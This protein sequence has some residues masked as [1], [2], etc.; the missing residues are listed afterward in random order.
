MTAPENQIKASSFSRPL[1]S[2][3]IEGTILPD[4]HVVL[5]GKEVDWAFTLTPLGGLVWAFCDGS[6]SIDE[7]VAHLLNLEQ[8]SAPVIK[9]T[10]VI[11]DGQNLK[12]EVLALVDEL[13]EA[14]LFETADDNEN[15]AL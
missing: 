8:V 10:P 2:S 7:I 4:G 6:N 5:T 9:E 13:R 14:G 3:S 1:R 12:D 11:I 15:T